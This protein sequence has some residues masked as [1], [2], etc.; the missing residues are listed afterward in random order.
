M[1]SKSRRILA[2]EA[3]VGGGSIALLENGRKIADW[4]GTGDVS[5][6]EDLL[7]N[8]AEMLDRTG[9]E[10]HKLSLIAVSNGPGSY[11]GIRIGLATALG[12]ARALNI[13]CVG[14]PLMPTIAE[15][16]GTKVKT[17]VVIPIGRSELCWQA[18]DAANGGVS[19]NQPTTGSVSD[20]I[21]YFRGKPLYEISSQHDAFEVLTRNPA[22]E[23]FSGRICNIGRNLALAIGLAALRRPSDLNPNYVRNSQFK[24]NP[25]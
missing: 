19:S 13:E 7:S 15:L 20:L 10:K 4:H 17:I 12:L 22:Y 5:R 25:L 2:I 11:T 21:E 6:A 3:A 9:T 14:V 24:S 1:S 16:R 18:F 23:E 8:I